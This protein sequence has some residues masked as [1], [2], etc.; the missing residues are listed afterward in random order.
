LVDISTTLAT[1]KAI[2]GVAKEAGKINLYNDIIGLQQ[3]I[4]ELIG[5]NTKTVDDNARLTREAIALRDKVASLQ[6]QLAQRDEMVFGTRLIG[7]FARGGRTKG[8][9]APSASTE[10]A[11]QLE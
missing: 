9:S 8:L 1:L 4:L 3:T 2:A 5:D 10:K 7:V 6:A 11:K